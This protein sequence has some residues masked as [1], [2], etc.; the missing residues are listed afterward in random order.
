MVKDR[1]G[2]EVSVDPDLVM[3]C[4]TTITYTSNTLKNMLVYS[5]KSFI[6]QK[7]RIQ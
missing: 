4:Y 7:S 6:L 5:K 3:L 2:A 1:V